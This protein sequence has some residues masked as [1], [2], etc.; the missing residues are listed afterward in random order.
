[1][2][3]TEIVTYLTGHDYA[4]WTGGKLVLTNNFYRLIQAPAGTPAE[5]STPSPLPIREQ[6]QQFMEEAEVPFRITTADG[7]QYTVKTTSEP[8][9]KAFKKALT[10]ITYADL[11]YIT[12]W[13]YKQNKLMRKTI[14]NYLSEEIW[15]GALQELQKKGTAST[16]IKASLNG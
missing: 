8:G 13:Y 5:L 16:P 11:V 12:K 3:L 15:Q 7:G 6:F 9:I 2:E 14:A 4:V 10:K 1:M